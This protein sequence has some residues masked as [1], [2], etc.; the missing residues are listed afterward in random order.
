MLRTAAGGVSH[1]RG[2]ASLAS[3]GGRGGS[4]RPPQSATWVACPATMYQVT[5][6]P[7]TNAP[8]QIVPVFR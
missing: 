6:R 4:R 8:V 5:K 7:F 2:R 1:A 3:G